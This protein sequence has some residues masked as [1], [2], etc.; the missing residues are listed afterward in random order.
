MLTNSNSQVP[1]TLKLSPEERSHLHKVQ[2]EALYAGLGAFVAA[3][4]MIVH[5]MRTRL[6]FTLT[7][8]GLDQ[9]LITPAFAELT[10]TPLL[11]VYQTTIST[12][13]K[14]SLSHDEQEKK[15][16]QE[17][18]INVCNRIRKMIE[19]RNEIVHGTWFIGWASADQMDFGE[20]DGFKPKN[21]KDGIKHEDIS[22]TRADFDDLVDQCNQ[23]ADLV[24]RFAVI[25]MGRSF[26]RNFTWENGKIILEPEQWYL[27]RKQD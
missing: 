23:L 3:F 12:A 6:M 7:R 19:R 17:I 13:I 24:N 25:D 10:A 22:C 26:T 15:A 16:G 14:K 8:T 27:A 2:T 9:Q 18:L 20:A 5:C 11:S 4:E 21:K 1:N